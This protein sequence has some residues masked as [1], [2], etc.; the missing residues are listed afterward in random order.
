MLIV[1]ALG[2]IFVIALLKTTDAIVTVTVTSLRKAFT[3]ILSFVLFS[4]PWSVKYLYGGIAIAAGAA[5]EVLEATSR[6]Q[7]TSQ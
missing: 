6:G 2:M 1:C 3:V 5:L 7:K 4:K